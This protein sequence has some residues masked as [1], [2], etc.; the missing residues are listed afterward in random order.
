MAVLVATDGADKP[1]EQL[2]LIEKQDARGLYSQEA[3]YGHK[4]RRL[5][6]M[7]E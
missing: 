3:S 1:F 2:R 5:S 4:R 6:A 7:Q